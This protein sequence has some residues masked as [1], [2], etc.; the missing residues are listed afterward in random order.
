MASDAK[1]G[2]PTAMRAVIQRVSE[3]SVAI[4]N[5]QIARIGAGI[6]ILLGVEK[7][8]TGANADWLARKIAP[9]RI[10]ELLGIRVFQPIGSVTAHRAPVGGGC[11]VCP[12]T[13][14]EWKAQAIQVAPRL[15][16]QSCEG[17]ESDPDDFFL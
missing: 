14:A 13:R 15:S 9:L 7:H 12:G 16:F 5:H 10:F 8:A 11:N 17:F 6:L 1:P 2:Y 3:A 4:E